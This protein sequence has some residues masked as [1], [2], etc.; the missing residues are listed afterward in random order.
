MISTHCL[1]TA[2]SSLSAPF[3]VLTAA[4]SFGLTPRDTALPTDPGLN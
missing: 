3:T 2:S 4:T 1:D